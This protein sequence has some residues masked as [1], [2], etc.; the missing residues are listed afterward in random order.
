MQDDDFGTVFPNAFVTLVAERAAAIDSDYTV[1]RRPLRQNDPHASV[2]VF[3]SISTP[4]EWEI[5]GVNEPVMEIYRV[6]IQTQTAH[7]DEEIGRGLSSFMAKTIRLM[8]Y[9][10]V[11][12][13]ARLVQLQD[14]SMG[15]LETV[16]KWGH[17]SQEYVPVQVD[18]TFFYL[19]NTVLRIDTELRFV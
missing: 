2:G 16:L 12:F 10:D 6:N 7:A 11:T 17:E 3:E 1:V 8:L 18:R 9:R 5:G 13:R 19:T 4:G 15:V 14:T